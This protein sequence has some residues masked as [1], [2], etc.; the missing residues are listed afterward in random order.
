M[1]W[2]SFAHFILFSGIFLCS[3][4]HLGM[5]KPSRNSRMRFLSRLFLISR[6]YK[7]YWFCRMTLSVG[8]EWTIGPKGQGDK[9]RPIF[10]SQLLNL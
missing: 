4:S 9:S 7:N 6:L 2:E 10:G 3:S 1:T 8:V 5:S